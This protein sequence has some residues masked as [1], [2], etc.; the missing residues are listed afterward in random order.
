MPRFGVNGKLQFCVEPAVVAT[1]DLGA[2]AASL[3]LE[4]G[5]PVVRRFSSL[6]IPWSR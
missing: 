3:R 5:E 1:I 2:A 4:E 6:V